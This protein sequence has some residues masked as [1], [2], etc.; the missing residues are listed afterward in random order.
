MANIK[1]S[2]LV[3]AG[4]DLLNDHVEFLNELNNQELSTIVGGGWCFPF[5]AY[6]KGYGYS[7]G[8]I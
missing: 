2:E 5:G 3:P 4:D 1:I 6:Y 7:G 8:F